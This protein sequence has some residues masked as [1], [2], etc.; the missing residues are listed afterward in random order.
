VKQN[1]AAR[2]SWRG[3]I[4]ILGFVHWKCQVHC[5]INSALPVNKSGFDIMK[6]PKTW[7]LEIKLAITDDCNRLRPGCEHQIEKFVKRIVVATL[8]RKVKSKI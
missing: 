8:R 2:E 1:D 6:A 7:A 5:A 3:E 4:N